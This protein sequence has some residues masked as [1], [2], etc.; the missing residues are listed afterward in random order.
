MYSNQQEVG[1]PLKIKD[2]GVTLINNTNAI[3]FRGPGVMGS[4]DGM[5]GVEEDITGGTE[6]DTLATVT[7]RGASTSTLSTFSGGLISNQIK[8]LSSAGFSILGSDGSAAVL[9]GV[10]GGQNTALY[11]NVGISKANP[12]LTLTGTNDDGGTIDLV[13]SGGN[14]L[15][16]LG[17]FAGD[18]GLY[19]DADL[20]LKGMTGVYLNGNGAGISSADDIS[21]LKADPKLRLYDT[22]N[23]YYFDLIKSSTASSYKLSLINQMQVAGG[24]TGLLFNGS[25]QQASRATNLLSGATKFS[26]SFWGK[27]NGAGTGNWAYLSFYDF[28]SL[29][30]YAGGGNWTM[31][32]NNAIAVNSSTA[33]STSAFQLV[34]I[35]YDNSLGSNN[36][37]FYINGSL[38]AQGNYTGTVTTNANTYIGSSGGTNYGG[39]TMDQL[40]IWSGRVLTSGEIG[41]IYNGG[42][43]KLF[44][45][46]STFASS[47]A[48][49]GTNLVGLYNFADGTGST[50]T[51]S[52]GGG[53]DFTTA[54]SPTWTTGKVTES[55]TTEVLTVL[56]S[57]YSAN[58]LEKGI[59]TLGVT[60]GQTRINGSSVNL[61][62]NGSTQVALTLSGLAITPATTITGALTANGGITLADATNI[63]VN[64][65]IGTKIATATTQKLGFYNATPIAQRSGAAQASVA[66]TAST[67]IT[68]Y[69][70][71]TQAQADAIVTLVNELRAW[72]VAQGFIKGS[73]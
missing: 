19:S 38:V 26:I 32:M 71:S 73:A 3:D 20:N 9:F 49:V 7:S 16:L 58:A 43:G 65:T 27:G 1:L 64:T 46:S 72:A 12:A 25:N 21:I 53:R 14:H 54:N 24:T 10:G 47:G 40:M 52:S 66:T 33:I 8:A 67:N 6:S 50:I 4:L 17:N 68:P 51:D 60:L 34:T 62:Y 36:I 30:V 2:E 11:G 22:T 28:N 29:S 23:N 56:T 45:S 48:S 31:R 44:T 13:D 15:K 55:P 5:G 18:P 42:T 39:V 41:N 69:G 59:H 70:Y 57:E 63:A 35:T 61:Q 37:K